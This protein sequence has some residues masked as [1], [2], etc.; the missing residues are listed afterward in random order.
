[1]PIRAVLFDKGRTLT[2]DARFDVAAGLSQLYARLAVPGAPALEEFIASGQALREELLPRRDD[3]D[4]EI[5]CGQFLTTLL[6]SNGIL[7]DCEGAELERLFYSAAVSAEPEPGA[8][9]TLRTLRSL[10]ARTGMLSNTFFS[11]SLLAEEMKALGL[12]ELLDVFLCSSTY[13]VRKPHRLIF[14]IALARLGTRPGETL[15]VGD[16]P[17][18]DIDGANRAGIVSVWYNP[19]A[20]PRPAGMEPRYEIRRLLDVV[21]IVEAGESSRSDAESVEFM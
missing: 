13:G 1:M 3:C 21:A 14:Q 16:H 2:T 15:F 9:A 12:Y 8:E 7:T 10:G 18:D 5:S 6:E 11:H 4:L 20:K 19:Q 17:R